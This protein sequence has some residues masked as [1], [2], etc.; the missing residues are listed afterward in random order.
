MADRV[1]TAWSHGYRRLGGSECPRR[2]EARIKPRWLL[3]VSANRAEAEAERLRDFCQRN[4]MLDGAMLWR[5]V[6]AALAELRELGAR[7]K[8]R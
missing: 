2:A 8:T 3:P 1:P 7:R 6:I 4:G 5:A